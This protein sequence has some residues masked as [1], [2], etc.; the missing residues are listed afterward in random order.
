MC[1]TEAELPADLNDVVLGR[2]ADGPFLI[3]AEQYERWGHPDFEIDV[4]LAAAESFSLEGAGGVHFI[5]Q[6]PGS[7][8]PSA[9]SRTSRRR[10]PRS[11]TAAP[12]SPASSST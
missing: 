9:G 12:R 7:C 11:S 8:A 10:S 2:I 1:L 6:S 4:A 3:D 5:S